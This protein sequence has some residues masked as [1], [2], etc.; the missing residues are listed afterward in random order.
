MKNKDFDL[1]KF[2]EEHGPKHEMEPYDYEGYKKINPKLTKEMYDFLRFNNTLWKVKGGVRVELKWT[3]DIL[4]AVWW[5]A[6]YL[7]KLDKHSPPPFHNLGYL[8]E[9]IRLSNP[10]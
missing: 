3:N 10:S 4:E 2:I 6:G 5:R 1:D 7:Q 9:A 8:Q